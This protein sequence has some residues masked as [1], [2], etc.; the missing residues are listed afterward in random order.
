MLMAIIKI[1]PGANDRVM[2]EF[3]YS[4]ELNAKV[5]S[6]PGRVW[7]PDRKMW[8]VPGGKDA[9]LKLQRLFSGNQ[10]E[11]DASLYPAITEVTR[12]DLVDYLIL[13]ETPYYG[14]LELTTFL[15][16]VWDLSAMSSTPTAADVIS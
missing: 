14:R 13:R 12:R 11:I 7:H 9:L 4:D 5:K 10:I 8:T 1:R 3:P 6:I 16:C 2:I 15:A